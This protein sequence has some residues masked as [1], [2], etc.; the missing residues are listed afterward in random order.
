MIREKKQQEIIKWC[1]N[2][3]IELLNLRH[4]TK[5]GKTRIVTTIKCSE[6]GE[7]YD[8]TWDNLK[9]HEFAGLCTCCAH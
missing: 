7:R 4:M 1:K 5:Q 8:T 9:V 2:K 6:C 3:Q